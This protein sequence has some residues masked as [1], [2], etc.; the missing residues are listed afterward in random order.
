MGDALLE[1]EL[2]FSEGLVANPAETRSTDLI[3]EAGIFTQ[4]HDD[5]RATKNSKP[6]LQKFED[7]LNLGLDY[8]PD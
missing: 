5:G 8:R 1:V 2:Q 6:T 3:D 7:R 4:E